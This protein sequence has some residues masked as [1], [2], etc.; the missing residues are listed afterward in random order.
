M[1]M[2]IRAALLVLLAM[3]A[4]FTAAEAYSSLQ[5]TENDWPPEEMFTALFGPAEEAEYYLKS[6]DG[7]VAVYNGV[8]ARSPESVTAI[9][10]SGLR[11][12]DKAMLER[13]IPVVDKETLLVLL[14]DLG[15]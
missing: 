11:G 2:R 3:T 1:K 13:G 15:S 14:E 10:T 6:C 4:A 12:T 8:R 5:P 9:E 7:F